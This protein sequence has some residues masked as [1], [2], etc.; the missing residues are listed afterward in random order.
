MRTRKRVHWAVCLS[1]SMDG[2][3]GLLVSRRSGKIPSFLFLSSVCQVWVRSEGEG[4]DYTC[5]CIDVLLYYFEALQHL[6]C[7]QRVR[8]TPLHI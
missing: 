6:Q 1:S 7:N 5:L 4:N 8:T 3:F 2:V